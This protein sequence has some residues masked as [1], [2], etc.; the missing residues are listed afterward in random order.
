[1]F[2]KKLE[3]YI[4]RNVGNLRF[5][6]LGLNGAKIVSEILIHNNILTSIDLS[7]NDIGPDGIE[8]ISNALKYNYV[9]EKLVLTSN[10]I[11]SNGIKYL[12][13]MMNYNTSLKILHLDYTG[14][15]TTGIRHLSDFLK[16]NDS[17]IELSLQENYMAPDGFILLSDALKIND[18]SQKLSIG[19][20]I[21]GG[22]VFLLPAVKINKSLTYLDGVDI[23][24]MSE[25]N[26]IRKY[27]K[28]NIK[29]KKF[30]GRFIHLIGVLSNKQIKDN[31]YKNLL[32]NVILYNILLIIILNKKNRKYI[33]DII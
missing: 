22:L 2:G 30:I 4:K 16:I 7:G 15:D 13:D 10:P 20:S 28:R 1:M 32:R 25:C 23:P 6:H 26:E 14:I 33:L 5:E 17:L 29:Y 19:L 11:G 31:L 3:R 12:V 21:F 8:L 27:I 18:T 9:L 24:T